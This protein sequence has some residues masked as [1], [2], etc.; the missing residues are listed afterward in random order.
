MPLMVPTSPSVWSRDAGLIGRCPWEREERG[1]IPT[2]I[3]IKVF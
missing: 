3:Q 1:E 2:Y